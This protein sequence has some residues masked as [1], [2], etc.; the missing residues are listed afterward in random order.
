VGSGPCATSWGPD[1]HVGPRRKTGSIL[2]PPSERPGEG[3]FVRRRRTWTHSSIGV[4]SKGAHAVEFSKT[5]APLRKGSPSGGV[6]P[7]TVGLRGGQMSI[8]PV[9]PGW[10]YVPGAGTCSVPDRDPDG[11]DRGAGVLQ[12]GRARGVRPPRTAPAR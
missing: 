3:S 4:R 8:A 7:E 5:V 12:V 9:Q 2:A 1:V 6:R 11:S 10:E